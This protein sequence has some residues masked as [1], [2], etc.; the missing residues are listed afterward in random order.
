MYFDF[1]VFLFY[2]V[3]MGEAPRERRSVRWSL[4]GESFIVARCPPYSSCT[5]S[6]WPV[7]DSLRFRTACSLNILTCFRRNSAHLTFSMFVLNHWSAELAKK[8]WLH[9]VIHSFFGCFFFLCWH[10]LLSV[11]GVEKADFGHFTHP[12]F[13]LTQHPT[14][15][16]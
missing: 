7:F 12:S 10:H 14:E 15:L 5:T 4:G 13:L 1:H 11:G 2:V 3:S 16:S 6:T 9:L 8:S